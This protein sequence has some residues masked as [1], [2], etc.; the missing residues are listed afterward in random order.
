M[1]INQIIKLEITDMTDDGSAVGKLDNIAV[2]CDKGVVGDV[3]SA[4]IIKVKKNYVVAK[5][6][7]ILKRSC[8]RIEQQLCEI[9]DFCGGCQILDISYDKQLK[10]KK[11]MVS[12]F[13][14]YRNRGYRRA[15]QVC[16]FFRTVQSHS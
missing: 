15:L 6:K 7:E 16:R 8:L 10:I 4:Q 11:D 1:N 3:V 14:D 13:Q 12:F 2:F 5:V 9:Q